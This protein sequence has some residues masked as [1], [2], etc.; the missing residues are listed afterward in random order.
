MAI[1]W[2]PEHEAILAR[3]GM[4][5][6]E[7]ARLTG[8]TTHAVRQKADKLGIRLYLRETPPT[9]NMPPDA[10][11]WHESDHEGDDESFIVGVRS[12]EKHEDLA[13]YWRAMKQVMAV[14]AR[15][16]AVMRRLFYSFGKKYISVAIFSDTHIGAFIDAERLE[17]DIRLIAETPDMRCVFLGDALDN[18]KAQGKTANGLYGTAIPSPADQFEIAKMVFAPLK[19]KCLAFLEGNHDAWDYKSAG[20]ARIPELAESIDAPFVSEAGASIKISV[21]EET[22]QMNVKH[23]WKGS[24]VVNKSNLGRRFWD[25]YPE[26]ENADIVATGHLHQLDH[27]QTMKRGEP[28]HLVQVGTYKVGDKYSEALGF[29]STYGVAVATFDPTEHRVRIDT[30]LEDG[31]RRLQS[32]Q[33][34]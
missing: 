26:W 30:T 34:G 27:H 19:G 14:Q 23:Q 3:P 4:T 16:H 20:I 17:E 32:F 2:N 28:V 33:E 29:K 31:I 15:R 5:I 21:G 6:V 18:F 25:E 24:S 7:A 13:A 22:Y 1:P 12:R 11:N 8:R 9:P 10:Q